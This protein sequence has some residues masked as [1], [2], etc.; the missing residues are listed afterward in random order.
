MIKAREIN[1]FYGSG[2][3]RF[4]VL[5]NISLTI[6]D[7]DFV[8]I[9]G[10]SGSGKSTLLNVLSGLERAESGQIFYDDTE[11]TG[12]TD[13]ELTAFR[14]K[15]IGFIFQQYYLLQNMNVGKNVK[16]GADL[17]VNSDYKAILKE[18]GLENKLY[19]FPSELSGGE[20]QRVSVARA[21]AKR[22]EVLF[23]DEPTGALD[24]DTGRQVLQYISELQKEYGFT[25]I[26]V[27]HNLNIAE[28]AK[29]VIRMNNG[30]VSE[31][32][33]TQTQKTAYEI[34]W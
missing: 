5:K 20:Q 17:A 34:G 33:T 15:K 11:I 23:L 19:K 30:K 4:Q 13:K 22:P 1:K 26:M 24:E 8:V 2:E 7:G 29:T 3:S 18:V 28:M 9:L 16:M 14:R 10:A 27:T 31:V 21:L 6:E 32:Y 12:L 25:I